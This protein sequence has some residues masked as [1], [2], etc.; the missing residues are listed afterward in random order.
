MMSTNTDA[1][2]LPNINAPL[3]WDGNNSYASMAIAGFHDPAVLRDV[4]S[5]ASANM[6]SVQKLRLRQ[7]EES[8]VV[9]LDPMKPHQA[10]VVL[11]KSAGKTHLVRM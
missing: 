2:S 10:F 11:A 8:N 9:L 3:A 5:Q 4:I 6:W 1:T 7:R